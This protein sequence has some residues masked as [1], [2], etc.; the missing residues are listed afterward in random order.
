M[1]VE[2]SY[3]INALFEIGYA[4]ADAINSML[5]SLTIFVLRNPENQVCPR[6][7][8]KRWDVRDGKYPNLRYS[9]EIIGDVDN[10]KGIESIVHKETG[11][12]LYQASFSGGLTE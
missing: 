3:D 9:C 11:K 10:F 2:G 6:G 4:N 5:N 8:V 1:E 12:R 7:S